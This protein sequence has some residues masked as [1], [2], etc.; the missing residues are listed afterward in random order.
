MAQKN[1]TATLIIAFLITAGLVGAGFW[2]FTQ[3]SGVNLG[4]WLGS[5]SSS[6]PNSTT[7]GTGFDQVKNVPSGL[8]A[9][10]GSTSW[11]PIRKLVNPLIET[12]RPEFQLRYADPTGGSVGSSSGV[13]ML[14]RDEIVFAQS[15]R[16]L[17]DAEYQQAERRNSQLKQIPVAVDGIAV[18]VNPSLEIPGLTLTQLEAIY[19]GKLTNW[20]SLGGPNVPIQPLARAATA[21]GTT[22]LFSETVLRGQR[23]APTVRIVSTTT[24]A[25][26]QLAQ[27]PGGIYFA[28]APEVVPQCTIKPIAIARQPGQFVRPYVEPLVSPDQCPEQRNRLNSSAFQRGDYPLTRNLYVVIK[29]NG[30]IEEQAGTAYANFLL[31]QQGQ[32]LIEQA[33]FVRI[34]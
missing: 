23:F 19:T 33:G 17:T 20:Q 7:G 12:A 5:D 29:Q 11:A 34:R 27:T 21:G 8:F 32:T 31:T 26:R 13:R 10:G 2:W 24:E 9:Y 22:E 16:P 14:I 18:A 6:S 25:L 15:S 1:E 3:R 4:R 28:S 30:A